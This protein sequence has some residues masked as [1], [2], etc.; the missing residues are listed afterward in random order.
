MS[1]PGWVGA[2]ASGPARARRRRGAAPPATDIDV[3]AGFDAAQELRP[4][5][6]FTEF[7]LAG[8]VGIFTLDTEHHAAQIE[9]EPG[10]DAVGNAVDRLVAFLLARVGAVLRLPRRRTPVP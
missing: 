3:A 10:A 5:D 1:G 2:R 8:R 9:V 7:L 4:V 6:G